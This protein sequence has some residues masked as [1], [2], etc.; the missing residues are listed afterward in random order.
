MVDGINNEGIHKAN[1]AVLYWYNSFES[2][3]PNQSGYGVN[4]LANKRASVVRY[5]TVGNLVEAQ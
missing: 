5:L 1:P 4:D 2:N 3:V